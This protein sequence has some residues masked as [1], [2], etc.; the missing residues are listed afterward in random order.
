MLKVSK[1]LCHMCLGSD[2]EIIDTEDNLCSTC[3]HNFHNYKKQSHENQESTNYTIGDL[4]KKW[5]K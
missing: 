5:E 3:C 1:G 2:L 4:K